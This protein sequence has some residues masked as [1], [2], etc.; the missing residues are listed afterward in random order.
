MGAMPSATAAMAWVNLPTK[1]KKSK[2]IDQIMRNLRSYGKIPGVKDDEEDEPDWVI[3][4]EDV[5]EVRDGQLDTPVVNQAPPAKVEPKHNTIEDKSANSKSASSVP[6]ADKGTK[7]KGAKKITPVGHVE[8]PQ[9]LAS[10][11][12]QKQNGAK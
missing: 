12:S 8:A 10:L 3:M 5:N 2:S 4:E 1:S 7:G 6:S 9:A 11:R